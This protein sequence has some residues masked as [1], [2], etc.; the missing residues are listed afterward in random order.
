MWKCSIQTRNGAFSIWKWQRN[1]V[2]AA[3]LVWYFNTQYESLLLNMRLYYSPTMTP[4]R[5]LYLRDLLCRADLLP[6]LPMSWRCRF[7]FGELADL[8]SADHREKFVRSC[9]LLRKHVYIYRKYGSHGSSGHI[10]K[11][12]NKI[13][14]LW[15][16]D[17]THRLGH[18]PNV[19]GHTVKTSNNTPW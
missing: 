15:L 18:T 4:T 16:K 10:M 17:V 5:W 8:P 1:Y 2:S 11:L 19:L 6:A 13:I 9:F 14:L 7:G 12:I 3:I